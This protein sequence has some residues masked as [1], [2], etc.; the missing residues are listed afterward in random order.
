MQCTSQEICGRC[1]TP[2]QLEALADV[3]EAPDA[4]ELHPDAQTPES[5]P[6]LLHEPQRRPSE[7][8]AELDPALGHRVA[9][10]GGDPV[11]DLAVPL[12]SHRKVAVE[13]P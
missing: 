7:V 4:P 5:R 8:E 3:V 6:Q 2:A 11:D 1:L 12:H 9:L 13:P 10:R